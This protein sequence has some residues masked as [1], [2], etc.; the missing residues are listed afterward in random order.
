VLSIAV[1]DDHEL[2][3]VGVVRAI[4]AVPGWRVVH[5]VGSVDE[6]VALDL[7]SIDVVVLDFLTPGEIQGLAAISSLRSLG[8]EVIV[9]T[10]LD[11]Q[12]IRAEAIALGAVDIVSKGEGPDRLRDAISR[13][14]GR[15]EIGSAQTTLHLTPRE[16]DVLRCISAGLRNQEVA[17]ELSISLSAVKRHLERIMEK[18]GIRTR[19]G[20]ANIPTETI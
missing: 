2:L 6:L 3:R 15:N 5:S 16:R 10:A 12:D 11:I 8:L 20:L 1:V 9:L 18:T 14:V 4:A 13:A 17:N 7:A 19:N